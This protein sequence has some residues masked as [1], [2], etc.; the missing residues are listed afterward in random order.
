M[1][2]SVVLCARVRCTNSMNDWPRRRETVARG[3]DDDDDD[4]DDDEDCVRARIARRRRRASRG[5]AVWTP[6]ARGVRDDA[7]EADEDDGGRGRR[8]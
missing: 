4:D 5:V 6:T 1:Y 8:G 2:V 7:V 3:R